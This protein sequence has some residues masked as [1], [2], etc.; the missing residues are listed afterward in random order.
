MFHLDTFN[1]FCCKRLL[2]R[3][4]LSNF[5]TKTRSLPRQYLSQHTKPKLTN[6]ILSVFLMEGCV[7]EGQ[8]SGKKESR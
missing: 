5:Y 7:G 8:V 1:E 2:S 4:Y 3:T 6:Q